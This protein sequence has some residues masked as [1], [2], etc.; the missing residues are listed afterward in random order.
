MGLAGLAVA[1]LAL[2]PAAWGEYDQG[3]WFENKAGD[4]FV[5]GDQ[6]WEWVYVPTTGESEACSYG[7]DPDATDYD[8]S[9]TCNSFDEPVRTEAGDNVVSILGQTWTYACP[10][11][12]K[13]L[14]I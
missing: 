8:Y 6:P 9:I 10:S 5:F 2:I 7:I 3:C 14:G 12:D 4:R 11:A 13:D 1:A